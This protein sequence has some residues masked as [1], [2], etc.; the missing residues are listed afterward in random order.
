MVEN[1]LDT[2]LEKEKI[3]ILVAANKFDLL[4]EEKNL[5]EIIEKL[6]SI[7][8]NETH[9]TIKKNIEHCLD[10]TAEKIEFIPNRDSF[11]NEQNERNAFFEIDSRRED[12]KNNQEIPENAC[13]SEN[14]NI[15]INSGIENQQNYFFTSARTKLN[16]ESCFEKVIELAIDFF[17]AKKKEEKKNI[18]DDYNNNNDFKNKLEIEKEVT[19]KKCCSLLF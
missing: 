14:S 18:E 10:R 3:P 2:Q 19:K 6:D 12:F 11:K 4:K 15:I 9:Q 7:K 17:E 8:K 16:V 1:N 13:I 5:N